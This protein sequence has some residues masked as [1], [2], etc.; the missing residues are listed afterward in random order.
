MKHTQGQWVFSNYS[1][2]EY[3]VYSEAEID[4]GCDIALIRDKGE[5]TLANARLISASP[6]LLEALE[7][8]D[9]EAH[10]AQTLLFEASLGMI[11]LIAQQAIAKARG[12]K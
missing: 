12:E 7:K 6:D 2:Y 8:I 11:R 10:N 5:S 4:D 1:D 9:S 3:G